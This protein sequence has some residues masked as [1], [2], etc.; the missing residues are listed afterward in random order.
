MSQ[1]TD[2]SPI[3]D[4]TESQIEKAE[5]VR[6]PKSFKP[7]KIIGFPQR[8]IDIIFRGENDKPSGIIRIKKRKPEHLFTTIVPKFK[9][10]P[11]K[12]VLASFGKFPI[13]SQIYTY[14]NNDTYMY[15]QKG[16][17][18]VKLDMEEFYMLLLQTLKTISDS[19]DETEKLIAASLALQLKG[20]KRQFL[21]VPFENIK[22]FNLEEFINE[23]IKQ[24]QQKEKVW[25]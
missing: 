11:D 6:T 23:S 7:T 14:K 1:N 24:S 2:D 4:T 15:I 18:Y 8:S 20:S 10:N 9:K 21:K 3:E 5:R 16:P 22:T 13:V 25:K 19:K 12:T 17:D